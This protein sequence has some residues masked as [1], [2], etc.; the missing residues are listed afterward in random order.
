MRK[1]VYGLLTIILAGCILC[2]CGSVKATED[3]AVKDEYQMVKEMISETTELNERQ[4][5]IMEQEGLSTDFDQLSQRQQEA[6][7]KI[8]MLM[9][10]LEDKYDKEF[11]YEGY[12]DDNY[13][14]LAARALDDNRCR[15]IQA[16]LDYEDGEYKYR[17]TY[18]RNVLAAN[19]YENLFD[20]FMMEHYPD[21]DYFVDIYIGK[22]DE[23]KITTDNASVSLKIVLKSC[24]DTEEEYNDFLTAVAEWMQN[25][26]YHNSIYCQVMDENDF[27]EANYFNYTRLMREGR[28][29]YCFDVD[30]DSDGSITVKEQD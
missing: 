1:N 22:L 27:K 17:D 14:S 6:A 19:D 26:K 5:K 11:V 30:I 23:E 10:Y 28:Y 16:A 8:E 20:E 18:A 3:K 15:K 21:P 29:R 12:N 4:K 25:D 13:G 24:F 2:G 9:T 7:I